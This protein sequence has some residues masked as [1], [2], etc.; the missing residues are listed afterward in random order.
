MNS[1]KMRSTSLLLLGEQV[2]SRENAS[3][4]HLLVPKSRAKEELETLLL[5]EVAVF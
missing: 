5:S 3:E 1:Y 2:I 4:T